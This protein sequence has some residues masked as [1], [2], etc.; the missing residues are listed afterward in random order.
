MST[1]SQDAA[2]FKAHCRTGRVPDLKRT[3]K[4]RKVGDAEAAAILSIVRHALSDGLGVPLG[5]D[6][7]VTDDVLRELPEMARVRADKD[8]MSRP[9]EHTR[10]A[11]VYATT[12]LSARKA[13]TRRPVGSP[14]LVPVNI[15][16]VPPGYRKLYDA[17]E[18]LV[19]RDQRW[20]ALRGAFR[21][22]AQL[23][24][25]NGILS[26]E[27]I[28]C[29]EQFDKFADSA[30]LPMKRRNHLLS[31]WR[32]ARLE[33]ERFDL[34]DLKQTIRHNSAGLSGLEAIPAAL[35][36]L[37]FEEQCA[38]LAEDLAIQRKEYLDKKRLAPSTKA[39]LDGAL[40]WWLA[41]RVRLAIDEATE[42]AEVDLSFL[43]HVDPKDDFKPTSLASKALTSAEQLKQRKLRAGYRAA[44]ASLMRRLVDRAAAR[45]SSNS[46]LVLEH[47]GN[48]V[49]GAVFFTQAMFQDLA[50]LR[51]FAY[52]VIGRD[53]EKSPDP[54][55]NA[56]W[57]QIQ[58]GYE[59]LVAEM[60]A[61]NALA[62]TLAGHRDKSRLHT[63]WTELVFLGLP[64][65]E[66]RVREARR[67]WRHCMNRV[68]RTDSRRCRTLRLAYE[69]R[70]T[71]YVVYAVIL[72]D[73][74]RISNYT[75]ALVGPGHPA[76]FQVAFSRDYDQTPIGVHSV[77]VVF[78]R[79]D[80]P[81]AQLKKNDRSDVLDR[82]RSKD[83][84]PGLVNFDLLWD[85]L[86]D[87]RPARLRRRGIIGETAVF[88]IESD[89]FALFVAGRNGP[90][91]N[92]TTG[93]FTEDSLGEV[94]GRTLHWV[95]V[96]VLKL[97]AREGLRPEEIIPTWKE[98]T[99]VKQWKQRDPARY[100][101]LSRWTA[102]F[103]PHIVRNLYNVYFYGVRQNAKQAMS[104]TDDTLRILIQNYTVFAEGMGRKLHEHGPTNPKWFDAAVDEMI[105]PRRKGDDWRA[106]WSAFD[107]W[108]PGRAVAALRRS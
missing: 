57:T 107:P 20:R 12:L 22:F 46:N 6:V 103:A 11:R 58:R 97:N 59:K 41:E 91:K 56:E 69:E 45:S 55:D 18:N 39:S 81:L 83:L 73:G 86:S 32:R 68:G 102:L 2:I 96:E 93:R 24:V 23:F 37:P 8:Q 90:K 66:A 5:S 63:T 71:E 31:G 38:A 98:L 53:L 62:G 67:L 77:R 52:E 50:A 16:D 44:G 33:A 80:E 64:A 7:E 65:L 10:A 26:P 88:D 42:G 70:L 9:S 49:P 60:R 87:V 105:R 106:F 104:A 48:L 108:E 30:E 79:N 17:L 74:M 3:G 35:R 94:F 78:R 15:A 82:V 1:F 85:Y 92:N 47:K 34:P 84:E 29:R 14:A 99:N 76:H 72:A 27:G 95:C 89:G 54:E 25:A 28:T 21:D 19:Q 36:A 75:G 51:L 13:D 61:S 4:M 101:Y 43:S 100:R 40:S